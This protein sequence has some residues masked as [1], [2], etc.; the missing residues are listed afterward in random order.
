MASEITARPP[1]TKISPDSQHASHL[2]AQI[3]SMS[4]LSVQ[5]PGLGGQA[6][7]AGALVSP[8][9]VLSRGMKFPKLITLL[10]APLL[11]QMIMS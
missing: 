4:W 3:M 2:C 7:G 8:E 9:N 5:S 11:K 1:D 10:E 6:R